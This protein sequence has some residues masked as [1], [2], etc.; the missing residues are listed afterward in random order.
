MSVRCHVYAF[1]TRQPPQDAAK[2]LT[3][4]EL[5]DFYNILLE[6]PKDDDGGYDVLFVD[7]ASKVGRDGMR[8]LDL[9]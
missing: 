9:D 5:P 4:E 1:L 8:P 7:A 6:R 2:K 3:G